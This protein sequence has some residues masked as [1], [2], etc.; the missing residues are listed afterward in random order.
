MGACLLRVCSL[1]AEQWKKDKKQGKENTG[2]SS[3]IRLLPPKSKDEN[4]QGQVSWLAGHAILDILQYTNIYVRKARNAY[5]AVFLP[6]PDGFCSSFIYIFSI[7]SLS[8]RSRTK[9]L[10]PVDQPR[11]TKRAIIMIAL[12]ALTAATLHNIDIA[13][14]QL[15]QL[16][17]AGAATVFHRLPFSAARRRRT[18]GTHE[19]RLFYYT[20]RNE[21]RPKLG[22][23]C[24]IKKT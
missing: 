24:S 2:D 23:M 20:G 10:R 12:L 15:Y 7:G 6:S 13:G 1:Q 19:L 22:A 9:A 4:S 16:T 8:N 5:D 18:Y 21:K 17:V 11:L 3:H 14:L